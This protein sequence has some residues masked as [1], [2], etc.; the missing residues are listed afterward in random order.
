ME[1]K[2]T[3]LI[4]WNGKEYKIDGLSKEQTVKDLKDAISVET[5]VLP[6]RQKLLGLKCKGKI[7]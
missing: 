2:L 7:T 1:D 3:I 5:G 6:P 4:K